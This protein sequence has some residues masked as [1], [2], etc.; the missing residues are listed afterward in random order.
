M[1]TQSGKGQSRARNDKHGTGSRAAVLWDELRVRAPAADDEEE[2]WNE[3]RV[4]SPRVQ[5]AW[6]RGR[7]IA[8]FSRG[9]IKKTSIVPRKLV[10]PARRRRSRTR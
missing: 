4:I 8:T 7:L 2:H 10:A 9:R 1:T 3:L 5:L 6:K